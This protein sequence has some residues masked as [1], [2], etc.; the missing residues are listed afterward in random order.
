MAT[1]CKGAAIDA[2]VGAGTGTAGSIGLEPRMAAPFR[3]K[4][5]HSDVGRSNTSTAS[6]SWPPNQKLT[7][8]RAHFRLDGSSRVILVAG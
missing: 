3:L 6:R 7:H 1:R 5:V 4:A 8:H 2:L